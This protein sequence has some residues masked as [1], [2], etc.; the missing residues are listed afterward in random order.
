VILLTDLNS[1]IPVTIAPGNVQ[2]ILAGDNSPM[3]VLDQLAHTATLKAGDQVVSS[4]DGGL[5][6]PG[7]PIGT[8]VADGQGGWRVALLADAGQAQDVEILKFAREPEQLPAAGQLPVE[9]AGMKAEAPPAANAP[10][11]GAKPAPSAN[12]P[13]PKPAAAKTPVTAA[14]AAAPKPVTVP[15]PAAADSDE[16]DQ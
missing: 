8:V 15:K 12:A 13:A 14:Q 3:P 4:G 11:S 5:L 2:A 1:R 9:A 10:A 7:L 16:T 6:P